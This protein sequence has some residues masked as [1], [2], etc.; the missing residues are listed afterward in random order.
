MDPPRPRRKG[1][2]T[3]ETLTRR[4]GQLVIFESPD[5]L[6]SGLQVASYLG[7][8]PLKASQ[9]IQAGAF[10]EPVVTSKPGRQR[11]LVGVP[12]SGVVRWS[13]EQQRL[14]GEQKRQYGTR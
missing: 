13:R 14:R 4:Q 11:T 10:G 6:L 5:T 2:N 3:K 9:L 12:F 1:G 7:I 8:A